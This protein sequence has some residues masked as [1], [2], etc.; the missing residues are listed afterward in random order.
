MTRFAVF[1]ALRLGKGAYASCAPFK[2]PA[3]VVLPALDTCFMHP[4]QSRP[5]GVSAVED[6]K[7]IN[8]Q[9]GSVG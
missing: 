5:K 6:K 3:Q 2:G 1:R 7:Y 4:Y 8:D 9:A